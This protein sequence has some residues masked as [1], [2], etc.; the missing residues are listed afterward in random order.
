MILQETSGGLLVFRQTDHAL[1]SAAFATAWGS[2]AFP[3]P[4]PREEVLI[5]AARHDDGWAEWELAPTVDDEGRPVDF[6]HIP[7]DEH[8]ELYSRGID[9]VCREDAF[10]GLVCSLH[11][12]R[13]YTRPFEA[14][15]DPRIE[16]LDGRRRELAD[17]YVAAEHHRQAERATSIGDPDVDV[18]AEEAWR[19]L[20]VWDR[21][22]LFVCMRPLVPESSWTMPPVGGIDGDLRIEVRGSE[23][24]EILLS[25]YPFSAEPAT[26]TVEATHLGSQRWTSHGDFRQ[27]FRSAER[28]TLSLACRGT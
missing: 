4:E 25:P 27:A 18:R 28:R 8:V 23:D 11:G 17:A 2:E 15:M 6:I 5:A 16:R 14:G 20:Q 12:E 9:L 13:L 7:V 3:P 22:S 19:L 24:G 1:L 26:F 21:L 10:A